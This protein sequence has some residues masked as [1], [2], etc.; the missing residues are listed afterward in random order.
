LFGSEKLD[1]RPDL[2]EVEKTFRSAKY[3]AIIGAISLTL[4]LIIIWPA[5]MSAVGIL[6]LAGF[7]TW[8]SA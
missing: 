7:T 5:I 6:S 2:D 1:N 4:V 3:T 8:V